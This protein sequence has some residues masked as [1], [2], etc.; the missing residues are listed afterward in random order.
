MTDKDIMTIDLSGNALQNI[1]AGIF[2][3]FEQLKILI[4][5]NNLLR[6]VPDAVSG[7][8]KLTQLHLRSNDI[9]LQAGDHPFATLASLVQLDMSRNNLRTLYKGNFLGLGNITTLDLTFNVLKAVARGTFQDM[10][11]LQS[12]NVRINLL[13]SN[14]V[15][16][17]LQELPRL[18]SLD[19]VDNKIAEPLPP[20][21]FLHQKRLEILDLSFNNLEPL[22][23]GTFK[24]LSSLVVL[25]LAYTTNK[26]ADR[27]FS[28]LP[29][30]KKLI[31][32]YNQL[33]SLHS[34]LWFGLGDTLNVL[35]M[36]YCELTELPKEL[37]MS[38]ISLTE[39]NLIGNPLQVV[40]DVSSMVQLHRL[41]LAETNIKHVYRC[42]FPRIDQLTD[43]QLNSELHCDCQL[44]WIK[45]WYDKC[46]YIKKYEKDRN[47]ICA[48]PRHN[49]GRQFSELSLTDFQCPAN[50]PPVWC[51]VRQNASL[52]LVVKRYRMHDVIIT[53]ALTGMTNEVGD[54]VLQYGV[55]N[56]VN[57]LTS[58][59]Y[60]YDVTRAIIED[61]RPGTTYHI[62]ISYKMA[63]ISIVHAHRCTNFYT[64]AHVANMRVIFTPIIIFIMLI[65]IIG[66]AVY[67]LKKYKIRGLTVHGSNIPESVSNQ[68][69]I[70]STSI[71]NIQ[72]ISDNNDGNNESRV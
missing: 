44:S 25:S 56:Q 21:V 10:P 67:L 29:S 31:L 58:Q 1:P 61:I 23:L 50:T 33:Q 8:S 49:R 68:E 72:N 5:D 55:L 9:T 12:L 69:N 34:E 11:H 32:D 4:A 6:S 14:F 57:Q 62:C 18:T 71:D 41:Y 24:G 40:P 53:W 70:A 63:N 22:R 39:L 7:L 19:L 59:R 28:D 52:S 15:N 45:T 51:G 48:S 47:Y 42:D 35:H 30:L 17:M 66:V 3:K 65:I 16:E 60:D 20:G 13:G 27:V 43:L 37:F 38:L 54:V 26:I 46:G 64:G 2:S 36:Q